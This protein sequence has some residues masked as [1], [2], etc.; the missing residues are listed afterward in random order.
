[1]RSKKKKKRRE[2]GIVVRIKNRES[3]GEREKA[4]LEYF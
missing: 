1:M 2:K 4:D 3:R